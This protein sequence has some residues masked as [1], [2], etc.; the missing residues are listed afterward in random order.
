MGLKAVKLFFKSFLLIFTILI[1]VLGVI[2]MLSPYVSPGQNIY[3]AYAGL[4]LP[5]ILFIAFLLFI[6][7]L[8]DKSWISLIPLL[9]IIINYQYITSMFQINVFSARDSLHSN[10]TVKIATYNIH[11]FNNIKGDV[12]VNSIANYMSDQKIDILCLQEF[13]PHSLLNMDETLGAF[14]FFPY[15]TLLDNSSP[16]AGLVIFSRFPIKYMGMLKIESL[17]NGVL[18]ADIEHPGGQIL[19]IINAHL[20]TTGLSRSSQLGFNKKI[21]IIGDNFK[22]REKQVNILSY[23]IDSSKTPVILCGDFNDTPSSYTYKKA[24]GNLTDGFKEAGSGLG[25]TFM[26]KSNMLRID[27]IMYSNQFKGIRYYSGYQKWSDH[28]PVLTEL[29]LTR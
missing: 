14:D 16:E 19:R 18:W 9:V 4:A 20:E 5:A 23:F 2:G 3:I 28:Y 12:P 22:L 7:W 11:Y 10:S 27:Y 13:A 8:S 26:H 6:F 29:E 21:K 17:S 25:G 24:K 1:L 15:S